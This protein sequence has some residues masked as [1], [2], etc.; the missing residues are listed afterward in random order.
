MSV[1]DFVAPDRVRTGGP[2]HLAGLPPLDTI[3]IGT[4]TYAETSCT[5]GS[6]H[7]VAWTTQ[8]LSKPIR[9][10]PNALTVAALIDS[11]T[12]T[13]LVAHTSGHDVYAIEPAPT[14]EFNGVTTTFSDATVTVANGRLGEMTV[15]VRIEYRGKVQGGR[16]VVRFSRYG[17]APPIEPPPADQIDTT[18]RLCGGAISGNDLAHRVEEPAVAAGQPAAAGAVRPAV[19]RA[20]RRWCGAKSN[21]PMWVVR[22]SSQM[23]TSDAP[24]LWR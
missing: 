8:E 4:T 10:T 6:V 14:R 15:E 20:S 17:N 13:R 21:G 7:E 1:E 18:L 23:T 9:G 2:S 12:A 22:C 24:H 3:I 11:A 19:T 5:A 16:S